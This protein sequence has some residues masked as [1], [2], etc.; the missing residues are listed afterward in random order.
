M[1]RFLT[2]FLTSSDSPATQVDYYYGELSALLVLIPGN[3][4][5]LP[6]TFDI[7]LTVAPEN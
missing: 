1:Q 5:K 4:E 6:F 2:Q 7:D 3:M